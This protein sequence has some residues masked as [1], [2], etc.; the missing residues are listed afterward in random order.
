MCFVNANEVSLS[1]KEWRALFPH[2]FP[3]CYTDTDSWIDIPRSLPNIAKAKESEFTQWATT[4]NAE[5][6]QRH[7]S[8][9]TNGVFPL[10]DALRSNR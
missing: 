7:A 3:L 2:G 8:C 4:R 1:I 6:A 10:F 9:P 5:R